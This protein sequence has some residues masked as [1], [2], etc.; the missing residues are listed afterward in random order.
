MKKFLILVVIGTLIIG[1]FGAGALNVVEESTNIDNNVNSVERATHTV[2]GEYGTATWCPYCKFAHG[3]LK[4]LYA[5]DQLDFYYVSLV[6]DKNSKANARAKEY[7]VSGIPALWWDGGYK[8]NIG[9]G[10]I[11]AAKADYKTSINSCGKRAVKDVDIGLTAIWIGGTKMWVD[12]TVTNY[13]ADTYGGTIRV[14]ITE[15]VSSRGWKDKGGQLYT[16]PFLDW[17]FNEPL[18]IDAGDSWINSTTWDGSTHG[19]PTVTRENIMIIAAAFNDVKHD[20][21]SD[22]PSGHHFDA[23]YV[24]KVVATEPKEDNPPD[25]PAITGPTNG[26]S[27]IEYTYY[28][29][30]NDPDGDQ[31]YYWFDWG[32]GTN[33]GWVGSYPSGE[34]GNANHTWNEQGTYQIKVKAIDQWGA[35]SDWGTLEVSMPRNKAINRPLFLQFLQNFFEK[36]PNAFPML[37]AILQQSRI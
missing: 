21:Y 30:T 5:E 20:G 18:S 19:Y 36:Y 22:P 15:K 9:A 6:T 17:A 26:K 28:A 16:F 14:Y 3:A 37:Q 32:D 4:E 34:T 8:V 2:L 12:V 24:D 25:T 33:S 23:Y 35:E 7:N 31:V 1:G 10:S 29:R 27:G 13:E 11:S